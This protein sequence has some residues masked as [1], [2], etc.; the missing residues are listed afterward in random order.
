M[1][2]VWMRNFYYSQSA[3]DKE[4]VENMID[5]LLQRDFKPYYLRADG[6]RELDLTN[7]K[8]WPDDIVWRK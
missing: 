3:R 4:L 8:S 1:E 2:W 6:G 5:L 7:W